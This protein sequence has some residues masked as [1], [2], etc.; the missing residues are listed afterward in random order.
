MKTA[1][2]KARALSQWFEH[3]L[4]IDPEICERMIPA[5][6]LT[7]KNQDRDT[8]HACAQAVLEHG[9][10]PA[11]EMIDRCQAACMNAKAL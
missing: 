5:L 9:N 3:E 11:I 4:C 7:I 10:A 6:E 1:N 2:E 8:R